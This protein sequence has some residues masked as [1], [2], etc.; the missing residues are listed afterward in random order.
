MASFRGHLAFS[1]SLGAAYGGL[2]FWQLSADWGTAALAAGLTAVGGMLPDLDSDSG[3]PVRELFG[4]AAIVVPLMFL[5]RLHHSWQ[6]TD[7]QIL[8]VIGAMFLSIRYG[9][10]YL[11][12][13][14]TVHRGMFHSIPAMLIAGLATFL[15][16]HHP[17]T[18]PRFML[19]IGVMIGFFSHLLLDEL[20]SV[21]LSGVKPK[22]NKYSGSTLK[23]GSPSQLA[24]SVTYLVLLAL[25]ILAFLDSGMSQVGARPPVVAKLPSQ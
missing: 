4:L 12:K 9:L 25:G 13:R 18:R 2:L 11:F 6:L 1:A 23:F 3:I 10:S 16:Y 14:L 5:R 7:E 24:T 15:I 21:D 19:A 8:V 22:L 20:Y 17:D